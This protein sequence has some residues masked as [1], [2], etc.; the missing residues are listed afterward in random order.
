MLK[1]RPVIENA[2]QTEAF[3]TG[4]PHVVSYQD[5]SIPI[6]MGFNS[7]EGIMDT[8]RKYDS[9]VLFFICIPTIQIMLK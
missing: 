2:N 7:A 5:P 6:I 1:Y 3:L 9:Q 4:D 8:V